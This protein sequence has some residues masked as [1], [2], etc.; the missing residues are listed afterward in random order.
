MLLPHNKYHHRQTARL[1]PKCRAYIDAAIDSLGYYD[2]H[3]YREEVPPQHLLTHV[4]PSKKCIEKNSCQSEIYDFNYLHY[5]DI[6]HVY[7]DVLRIYGDTK[8]RYEMSGLRF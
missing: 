1:L 5:D 3:P 6:L 4:H 7:K 2:D 8:L